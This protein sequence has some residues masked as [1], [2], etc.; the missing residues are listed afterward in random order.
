MPDFPHPPS[1]RDMTNNGHI[2]PPRDA[3]DTKLRNAKLAALREFAYGAGHE[4][5]NPLANISARAQALLR[6]ETDTAKRQTLAMIIAQAQRAHEMIADLMLFA[7][8]PALRREK[9][10]VGPWLLG[11]LEKFHPVA[12]AKSVGLA[13]K[14][15]GDLPVIFA[16]PVQLAVA[17]RAVLQNA[18]DVLTAGGEIAVTASVEIP[19]R[20]PGKGSLALPLPPGEGRSEGMQGSGGA[21]ERW[22]GGEEVQAEAVPGELMPGELMPGEEANTTPPL[23]PG[24]GRGEGLEIIIQDNG[25]GLTDREREHL[26]DPFFSGREAGR[27]LGFGLCKAWRIIT[28]HGGTIDVTS[29]PGQGCTARIWLPTMGSGV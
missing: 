22:S 11:L 17:L 3:F 8:P 19:P 27:G 12:E 9:I 4:I 20:P 28:D 16:D 23:P 1:S 24:E 14:L 7:K 13:W 25:P 26:F 5:N 29:E 15:P 6:G 18:C 10:S 21:G 2:A